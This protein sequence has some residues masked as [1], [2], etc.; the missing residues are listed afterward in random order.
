MNANKALIQEIFTWGM[1][2]EVPFFQRSY[3]WKEEL[4]QR[5][6]NDMEF[7]SKTKKP[8]FFGTLILKEG[9]KR[10]EGDEFTVCKTV[11]DGQQRLTTLLLLIKVLCLKTDQTSTFNTHFKLTDQTPKLRHGKN[12]IAAFEKVMDATAP[13]QIDNQITDSRIIDAFN[14]FVKHLDKDKLDIETILA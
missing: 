7:V 14:F 6:L 11:V 9:R 1:L 13:E 8:H 5:L 2:I 4:W 10:S 3:V 12:D